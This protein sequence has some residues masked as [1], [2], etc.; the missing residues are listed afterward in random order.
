MGTRRHPEQDIPAPVDEHAVVTTGPQDEAAGVEAV[1]VSLRRGLAQMGPVRTAAALMR[2]NQ[3]DGFDCPGCAWPEEHGRP[4]G[5]RVLRERRQSGRRGGHQTGG[6]PGVLRPALGGRP[7]RPPGVLAVPAG[8][9]D[10]PDG[11]ARRRRPLP[12]D[13]LG[14]RLPADRRR[15]AG[16][17]LPRRGGVLHLG[18][19]Q[20]RGGVP[21]PADGAQLRHQQPAGL[22]EHVPRVLGHRADRGHRHRQGVGDGRGPRPRRPDRH[23]R[24]EPG[25]QPSRGCCRCWR[26]PR[27]TAR[28]SSRSTRCPRPG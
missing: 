14:R 7:G 8:P 13:R 20:Q 4:Q 28:R 12:A 21:L 5:G 22:L 23:R 11:A 2:M 15:A 26:R 27:P 3:R 25:H 17:G 9:A 18:A 6:H 16:P 10:P 19:H 24:A 1:W